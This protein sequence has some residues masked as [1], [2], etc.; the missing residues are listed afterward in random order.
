MGKARACWSEGSKAKAK[1]TEVEMGMGTATDSRRPSLVSLVDGPSNLFDSAMDQPRDGSCGPA[2]LRGDLLEGQTLP[3]TE[4]HGF[5]LERRKVLDRRRDP[6]EELDARELAARG[7]RL[8]REPVDHPARGV[9]DGSLDGALET[10][11][12]VESTVVP[13]RVGDGVGQDRP[14]PREQLLPRAPTEL[15]AVLPGLEEGF[16]D[17]VG[18]VHSLSARRLDLPFG[19]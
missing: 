2:H 16:L 13:S 7:R 12:A 4:D 14:Q 15:V 11:V 9:V 8:R 17:H 10:I 5:P 1:E 18:G 19:K 3:V 6:L